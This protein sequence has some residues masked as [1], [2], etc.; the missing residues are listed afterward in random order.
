MATQLSEHVPLPLSSQPTPSSAEESY[1]TL[2]QQ[3]SD[4]MWVHDMDTGA[5]LDLNE[6]AVEFFGYSAEEQKAIGVE[7][8]IVPE[9]GCTME[10]AWEYARRAIAG[11]PQRFEWC[12]RR[13]DGT[14]VWHEVR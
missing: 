10:R 13:K 8:L 12:G 6:A 5:M 9:S 3:A 14:V 2:F 4:A 1:R 7:G 11:E